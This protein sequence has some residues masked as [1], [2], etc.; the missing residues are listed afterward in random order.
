[1][2]IPVRKLLTGK[3]LHIR[4]GEEVLAK[5]FDLSGLAESSKSLNGVVC[6]VLCSIRPFRLT[7]AFVGRSPLRPTGCGRPAP[8]RSSAPDTQAAG[9]VADRS[10]RA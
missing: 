7:Y 6:L 9:A 3:I 1:V 8:A 4:S 10:E 5:D 2:L